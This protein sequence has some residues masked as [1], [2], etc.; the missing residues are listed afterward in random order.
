MTFSS[1]A[2][3]LVVRFFGF[4]HFLI[5]FGSGACVFITFTVAGIEGENDCDNLPVVCFITACTGLGYSIQRLIKTKV[6]PSSMPEGRLDFLER[7]GVAL[8][9]GWSIVWGCS[10]LN[11]SGSFTSSV[12]WMLI[13]LVSVG[14]SY[15]ILPSFFHGLARSVREIPGAKL[16][17]L[18]LVWGGATVILPLMMVD[19]DLDYE[20]I[21]WIFIARIIYIAGLTIP[22]DVRDLNIDNYGMITLP[23]MMGVVR[24]LWF[25]SGLVVASGLVYAYLKM[26]NLVFHALFTAILVCPKVYKSYWGEWYYSLLLDGMLVLLFIV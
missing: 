26:Y 17:V 21:W 18:S 6:S 16:P 14:L 15:A 3:R 25:A 2:L 1:H 12:M 4:S 9:V 7:Y 10:F 13:A 22:F 5:A 8:V 24:S 20:L 19:A 11:I 23:M